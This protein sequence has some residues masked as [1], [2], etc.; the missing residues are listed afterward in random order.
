MKPRQAIEMHIP[1]GRLLVKAQDSL[2]AT[3]LAGHDC[4][5]QRQHQKALTQYVRAFCLD[6]QQPLTC[7][8]L[9]SYLLMLAQHKL[10]KQRCEIVLKGV[11]FVHR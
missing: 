9:G 6:P 8:C 11:S 7:L 5:A 10:S 4:G 3:L 1:L 2:P